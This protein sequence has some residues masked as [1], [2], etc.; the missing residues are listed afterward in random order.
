MLAPTEEWPILPIVTNQIPDTSGLR[1][2]EVPQVVDPHT[3]SP[4]GLQHGVGLCPKT[5]SLR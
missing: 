4:D 1:T 5:V 2:A 3:L